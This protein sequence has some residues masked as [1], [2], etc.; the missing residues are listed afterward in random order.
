[1]ISR[2][3]YIIPIVL[4][5]VACSQKRSYKEP[6]IKEGKKYYTVKQDLLEH[7]EK[8]EQLNQ[9]KNMGNFSYE[10]KYLSADVMALKELRGETGTP[11]DYNEV[12]S[13]YSDLLYFSL[14][15]RNS[16]FS[17]ELLRYQL[18]SKE[19]YKDRINYCSFYIQNDL[20]LVNGTDSLP[21]ALVQYERTFNVSNGLKFTMAFSKPEKLSGSFTIVFYDNL[22][23]N[24]IIKMT[25]KSSDITDAPVLM[26]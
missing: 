23:K 11:A 5:M 15:I 22:F 8:N 25:F 9:K 1:M 19:Q 17:S 10:L 14:G 26:F 24:G 20:F 21:C 4:M 12:K 6:F 13:H 2:F 18:T 3:Y 16:T 7:S